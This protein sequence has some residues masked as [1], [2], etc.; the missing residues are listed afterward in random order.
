MKY[1]FIDSDTKTIA[2]GRV[3]KR[4]RSLVTITFFG[5]SPG[6][7]GGYVESESCLS[8]TGNAW[9]SGGAWVSGN[10][11]KTPLQVG[12]LKWQVTIT[13]S[14]MQIGCEFHSLKNWAEFDDA[15]I[16]KMGGCGA[17]RFW[18]AHKALL[19]GIASAEGRV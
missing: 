7:L 12:G 2:P 19:L 17:L 10:A 13:D 5:I 16:A 3:A 11:Q 18:H 4:I 14:C 1:E 6:D 15:R 8:Q 9:V